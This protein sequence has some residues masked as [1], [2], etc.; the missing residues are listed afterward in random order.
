[1]T[2]GAGSYGL[3]GWGVGAGFGVVTAFAASLQSV[4]VVLTQAPLAAYP[5]GTGDALNPLSWSITRPDT[6]AV[7]TVATVTQISATSFV[8]TTIERLRGAS[9]EYRLDAS[10]VTLPTGAPM[11]TPS[12]ALFA[13]IA[14]SASAA[15]TPD[16]RQRDFRNW[17]V[18]RNPAGGTL[19][20]GSGGDYVEDSGAALVRKLVLRRLMSTPGDWFHLPAYGIG[21]RLKEPLAA[22]ALATLQAEIKRQVLREI[23]VADAAVRLTLTTAGALAVDVRARL[24]DGTDTLV[25]LT[26]TP[27]LV[28]F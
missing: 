9:T 8:L 17:P 10:A 4:R 13:G 19:E 21:L 12:F 27:D 25:Q 22:V 24:R 2:W 16:D 3:S 28:S 6:G 20:I 18:P 11:L 15:A 23:E 14:P 7:F 5:T 26:V 1:M